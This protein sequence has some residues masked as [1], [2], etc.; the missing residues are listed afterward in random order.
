[1]SMRLDPDRGWRA[2]ERLSAAGEA[3]AE[4]RR[5][6]GEAIAAGSLARPWSNDEIGAA[7]DANYQENAMALLA[8]WQGAAEFVSFLADDV[9]LAVDAA[10]AADEEAAYRHD[11]I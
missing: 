11:Q 2:G 8:A 3:I 7:F 4:V 9:R 6:H 10:V 5:S 1:M